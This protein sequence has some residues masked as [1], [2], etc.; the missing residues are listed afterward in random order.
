M[1]K[2]FSS[3]VIEIVKQ[4]PPGSFLTYKQVA[5]AVK[6]PLAWRAVGQILSKNNNPAVPCHRVIKSNFEVGGFRGSLENSWQK[7][8][9]LLKEGAIGVIPTDTIYGIVGSALNPKTVKKIYTLRKRS[10]Q[11]PFI[12]LIS[13]LEDL[14]LFKIQFEKWQ[15][16]FLKKIT[17]SKI[18]FIL[19]CAYQNLSYLHRGAKTLAFR[20]PA[21]SILLKI[22]K[23]SGPLV[24]PSANYE[25]EKPATT[26]F[27]AK[28][29]FGENVFYWNKGKKEGL[30][31]TLIDLT[32][33]PPQVLRKGA[34]FEKI[35]TV[36][37]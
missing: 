28:K 20:V 22:L 9:L 36:F 35:K 16:Q 21:S 33:N 18:S 17:P 31:S 7:V 34:D 37:K 10:P 24:A 11:K 6:N 27:E 26:I 30:P 4:I 3:K 29:Y 23:I 19:P 14:N 1:R 2:D 15:S 12:I 25:G 13:S 8:A 5:C 32:K